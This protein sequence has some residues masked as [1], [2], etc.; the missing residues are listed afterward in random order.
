MQAE[1]CRLA[2]RTDE[3][4]DA[5]NVHRVD[6]HAQEADRRAAHLRRPLENFGDRNGPEH[7]ERA[8]NAEHE[9]EIADAVHHEGLDGCGI[10]RWLLE[11]EPDEQIACQSDAFPAEEHLDQI[12]GSHQH[13]HGEGEER[14]IGEEAWLIRVFVHIAP[15]IQMDERGH[16]V[17]DHEHDRGQRVHAQGP[18]EG[19]VARLHPRH[20]R[21]DGRFRSSVYE[22]EEDRPAQ[23]CTDEQRAGRYRL[24]E[25]ARRALVG[26]TGDDCCEQRQEDD[27]QDGGLHGP[28]IL[29]S[30]WHR[31]PQSCRGHGSRS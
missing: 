15:A 30:G 14:Q 19:Q 1:L 12:V 23:D 2:H 3:Q 22:A 4:K 31:R 13:Q 10:G 11:P 26:E 7:P 17:D 9:A 25:Y 6:A 29:S 28:L 5:Q 21:N 20:D 27:E 18:V 16:R 24:R 8:E